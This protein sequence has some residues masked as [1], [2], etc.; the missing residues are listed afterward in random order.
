MAKTTEQK[1]SEYGFSMQ[2]ANEYVLAMVNMGQAQALAGKVASLGINA[3]DLANI[4]HVQ[5]QEVVD[6]FH[7]QGVD[8]NL[9]NASLTG[10]TLVSTSYG[11]VYLHNPETG[12][13]KLVV[14]FGGGYGK[15]YGDIAVDTNGDIYAVGLTTGVDRFNFATQTIEHLPKFSPGL[16]KYS[17]G[18]YG[19]LLVSGSQDHLH[20]MDKAGNTLSEMTVPMVGPAPTMV[21]DLV[22]VGDKL[23]RNGAGSLTETDINTGASQA[24]TKELGGFT[25]GM[26]KLGDGW[27]VGYNA[28]VLDNSVVA[29][30]VNSHEVKHL[31]KWDVSK[32]EDPWGAAEA[33][34]MHVDLWGMV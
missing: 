22:V 13:G 9:L 19:D 4:V 14:K 34:Q 28:F 15:Q 3:Q 32:T 7:Y 6:Y 17:L 8:T 33:L 5:K 16:D 20:I 2:E 29:F 27:I 10:Y 12:K 26:A 25:A 1:L 11:D 31:P 18:F 30:N 24:V 21:S 23:Y